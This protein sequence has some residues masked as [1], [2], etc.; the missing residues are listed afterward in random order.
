VRQCDVHVRAGRQ[1]PVIDGSQQPVAQR[2]TPLLDQLGAQRGVARVHC[3]PL[4]ERCD[5][6]REGTLDQRC[7][8]LLEVG[9]HV[10]DQ[11]AAGRP[12]R[13]ARPGEHVVQQ[14]VAGGPVPVGRASTDTGQCC[15]GGVR[16][17]RQSRRAGGCRWWWRSVP[18]TGAAHDELPHGVR[19]GVG[20]V[21]VA[22][23]VRVQAVG[24]HLRQLDDRGGLDDDRADGGCL[25][26]D[27]VVQT[28][29]D[30]SAA[31]D[32]EVGE[33]APALTAGTPAAGCSTS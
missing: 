25:L 2:R 26:A 15:D 4:G 16:H 1:G 23:G 6:Q 33:G 9:S 28:E 14:R 18:P 19:E 30:R 20:D 12:R 8:Q 24:L 32:H 10:D 5:D 31:L 29:G 21:G 3:G 17:G 22:C 11:M 27:D 7:A 13:R